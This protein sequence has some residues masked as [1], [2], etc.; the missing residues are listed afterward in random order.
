[1]YH[2]PKKETPKPVKP[3]KKWQLYLRD[4]FSGRHLLKTWK[5]WL[6]WLIVFAVVAFAAISNEQSI[7]A[8][9]MRI[10]ELQHQH[11]SLILELKA[12][13][14]VVVTEESAERKKAYD[15]G[16]V[17]VRE[18]NYYVIPKVQ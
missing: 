11:D 4:V 12:V 16:F 15:E 3:P 1:M 5:S 7:G 9:Q 17:D 10:K 14:E 13:N 8:K 18:N 2:Q 6:G